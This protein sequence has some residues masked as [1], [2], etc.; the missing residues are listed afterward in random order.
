MTMS[1]KMLTI[2]EHGIVRISYPH[3]IY[4]IGDF[5]ISNRVRK[6]PREGA[7]DWQGIIVGAYLTSNGIGYAVRSEREKNSVQIYPEK[8]LELLV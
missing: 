8:A 1:D 2:D 3:E 6:I 5:R 7:G 4:R